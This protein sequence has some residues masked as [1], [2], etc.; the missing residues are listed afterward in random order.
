MGD[1]TAFTYV[2]PEELFKRHP[3]MQGTIEELHKRAKDTR[4]CECC[5]QPA[6]RYGGT[7]M[8]FTCTTGE[9]DASDDYEL[10]QEP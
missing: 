7:G 8:C 9:S 6:W 10:I 1:P 2:T 5:G 4:E 3:D